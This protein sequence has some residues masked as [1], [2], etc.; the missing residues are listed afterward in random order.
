MDVSDGHTKNGNGHAE[1]QPQSL[2]SAVAPPAGGPVGDP[3]EGPPAGPLAVRNEKGQFLPGVSGNPAGSNGGRR[4]EL[5]TKFFE[6]FVAWFN[7]EFKQYPSRRAMQIAH[8]HYAQLWKAA[9]KDGS[10]F[11]H[12]LDKLMECATPPAAG[13]GDGVTINNTFESTIAMLRAER[14]AA[15]ARR[16]GLEDLEE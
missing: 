6:G 7:G 11:N 15:A 8:Q 13:K 16:P 14:Q 12:L 10:R 9:C 2:P 4:D 1:S 5:R 3:A